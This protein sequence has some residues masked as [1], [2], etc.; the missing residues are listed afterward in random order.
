MSWPV[1]KRP[2]SSGGGERSDAPKGVYGSLSDR[3]KRVCQVLYWDLLAILE[4]PGYSPAF[5]GTLHDT[6]H[7]DGLRDLEPVRERFRWHLPDETYRR[8]VKG[9]PLE[10]NDGVRISVAQD[11]IRAHARAELLKG[12]SW[13]NWLL[14]R[15]RSAK[16]RPW[17]EW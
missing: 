2:S 1:T 17:R 3:H 8:A 4:I 11:H 10:H 6:W 16:S 5:L 9:L 14:Y 15:Y 13:K 12:L 7:C